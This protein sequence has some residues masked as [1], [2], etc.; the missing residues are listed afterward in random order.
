M[1]KAIPVYYLAVNLLS[2]LIMIWDKFASIRGAS[3]IP[4]KTLWLLS[5]TGGV[6]GVYLAGRISNHK[7][8]KKK[9]IIGL[10]LLLFIHICLIILIEK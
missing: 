6:F 9:F 1:D 3:R 2:F 10:P 4:E 7:T 8:R 5:F